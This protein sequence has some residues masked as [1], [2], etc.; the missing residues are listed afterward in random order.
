MGN[1][2]DAVGIPTNGEINSW[3]GAIMGAG[4]ARV[5]SQ[6]WRPWLQEHLGAAL[7]R[8]GNHVHVFADDVTP[9][10]RPRSIF[11]FPTKHKA[12][13]RQS[14]IRLI[15]R[16]CIELMTIIKAKSWSQV[17]IPQ[18]GCGM[19]RLSWSDVHAVIAPVCDGRV[20]IAMID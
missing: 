16:S 19:G 9:D 7:A 14:D 15:E 4:V 20:H 6:R 13:D 8:Y 5:A 2:Y 3:G 1:G 12:R 10:P 17:I 18:P 11:S